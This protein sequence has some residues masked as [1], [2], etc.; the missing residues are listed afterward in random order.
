MARL[1]LPPALPVAIDGRQ[2]LRL[3]GYKKATDVPTPEVL[4]IRDEALREAQAHIRARYLFERFPVA[5]VSDAAVELA[6]GVRLAITGTARRWGAIR[7]VGLGVCT[8]GE[9]LERR[10]EAL[11]ARR[12]FPVAFMLDSAG[13]VAVETLANELG[14]WICNR[15]I[16]EG[17]KAAPRLSPGLSGWDIWD[18]RVLFRLLP[19]HTIDVRINDYCVMLP[20]KSLSFGMGL[21]P[22]VRVDQTHKCR[23]CDL[24][25]CAYRLAP[26]RGGEDVGDA[27]PTAEAPGDHDAA[28]RR[29]L[30]T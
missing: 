17:V 3:Q 5:S 21:G 26:Y 16:A 15:L 29:L 2:V 27:P 20:G 4:A 6:G 9:G 11:L 12:E 8:I 23:R 18:Q 7:E 13:W 24:A 30:D 1:D 19:A 14:H 22:D 28:L 25:G 10:V